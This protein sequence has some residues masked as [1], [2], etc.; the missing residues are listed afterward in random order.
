MLQAEI[1]ELQADIRQKEATVMSLTKSRR[2]VESRYLRIREEKDK[3]AEQI[4][5]LIAVRDNLKGDTFKVKEYASQLLL[6]K[7]TE[8]EGWKREKE[9]MVKEI[10]DLRDDLGAR[11]QEVIHY[12]RFR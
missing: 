11:R 10:Q 7:E 12:P 1:A 8:A 5:T 3:L 4:V 2:T 6:A 9:K